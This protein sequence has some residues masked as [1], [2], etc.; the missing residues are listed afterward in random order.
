MKTRKPVAKARGADDRKIVKC[1]GYVSACASVLNG[2]DTILSFD[3]N[4]DL[5]DM[6]G[7]LV[8]IR[9]VQPTRNVRERGR[10]NGK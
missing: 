4:P 5:S 2:H 10:K 1:V 3:G 6:V 9:R 8:E 7:H